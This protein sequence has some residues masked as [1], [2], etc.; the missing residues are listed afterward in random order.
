MLNVCTCCAVSTVGRAIGCDGLGRG[1]VHFAVIVGDSE[2]GSHRG[3][4]VLTQRHG[5]GPGVF[6]TQAPLKNADERL[7]ELAADG[8]VEDEIDAGV[9][10]D[11]EGV[12]VF[13]AH[14]G[15]YLEHPVPAFGSDGQRQ[16]NSHG[17]AH[18]EYQHSG[19][20]DGADMKHVHGGHV[21]GGRGFVAQHPPAVSGQEVDEEGVGH[22][23]QENRDDC[24]QRDVGDVNVHVVGG[25]VD[26]VSGQ[27]DL[28][29][30]EV[31]VGHVL[32]E[33]AEVESEGQQEYGDDDQPGLLDGA[34]QPGVKH[35]AKGDKSFCGHCDGQPSCASDEYIVHDV[36]VWS[37]NRKS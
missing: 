5:R 24:R 2:I 9:D 21:G 12:D 1:A 17:M 34:D 7:A 27:Q 22:D 11:Q 16:E 36:S 31:R 29:G 19:H 10:H 18:D 20:D 37:G 3:G 13:E 33:L 4:T 28:C 6:T 23:Q 14:K 30:V 25:R 15:R 32:K 26:Q 8:A 35:E